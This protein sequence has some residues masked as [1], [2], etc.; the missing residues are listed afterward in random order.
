M[1]KPIF[2]PMLSIKSGTFNIDFYKNVFG[3]IELRRFSNDD[4]SIHVSELSINGS[5]F[6]LH[7]EGINLKS[8]L[9]FGVTTV[10]VHLMVNH[11]DSLMAKAIE[12]GASNVSPAVDYEYGYRQGEFT[13]PFGHRWVIE[14]VI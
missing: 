14:K 4:G 13:D 10:D 2:I 1:E 11:V 12:F 9:D 6:R 7:E 8:P 3:A 5:M